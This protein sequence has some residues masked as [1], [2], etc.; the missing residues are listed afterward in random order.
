MNVNIKQENMSKNS[1]ENHLSHRFFVLLLL[2]LV[3]VVTKTLSG[4]SDKTVGPI[5]TILFFIII[6]S[7]IRRSAFCIS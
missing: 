3:L 7:S 5:R 2:I 4:A 1:F 6:L